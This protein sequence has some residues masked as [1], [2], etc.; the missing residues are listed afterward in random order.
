MLF[1]RIKDLREHLGSRMHERLMEWEHACFL[2][3]AGLVLSL[4]RVDLLRVPNEEGWALAL[5]AI[6]T[7][8]VGGLIVNGL[9]QKVTSWLRAF[10]SIVSSMMFV[11][12]TLGYVW[13]GR[14][15]VVAAL[16]LITALFEWA[17]YGRALRDVGRAS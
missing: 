8:R 1:V 16:C 13:S 12:L 4:P 5:L 15:G 2:I 17:N 6:G 14:I 11:F 10:C 7:L 9:R 3:A